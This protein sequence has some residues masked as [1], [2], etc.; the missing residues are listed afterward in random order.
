MSLTDKAIAQ[1]RSLIQS[2]E[3]PPGSRLPPEPELAAMLG[4][5]RNLAREAVKALA[6]ARILEVRRGDGTYVTSLSPSL[7]FE[8]LGGAVEL[9][10]VDTTTLL[11]LLEARRILEPAVTALAAVRITAEGLAEVEG[12]LEGMRSALH[13]VDELIL[14][15]TAFHAA[16]GAA[17]GN[18][19]LAALLEGISSRT[20]RVRTWR[21][22]HDEA[23]T[24]RSV[25]EHDA[26]FAALKAH[27]VP[28]SQATAMVH[29]ASTEAWI[30]SHID[31]WG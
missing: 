8:G 28:M 4:L 15:D 25:A 9:L 27:D 31:S 18:T 14:H 3:L 21:G 2:G 17:T 12:H 7:L 26:I 29:V 16:I 10:Q 30:R 22:L 5:S 19:S 20:V 24:A 11:E 13:D 1:I 6:V 23:A